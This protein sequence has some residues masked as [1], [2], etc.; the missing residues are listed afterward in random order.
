MHSGG[1]PTPC[2]SMVGGRLLCAGVFDVSCTETCG[3]TRLNVALHSLHRCTVYAC[4]DFR[5]IVTRRARLRFV[6]FGRV[7]VQWHDGCRFGHEGDLCRIC[8]VLPAGLRSCKTIV[9]WRS[10]KSAER[11]C[12][13]DTCISRRF[14]FDARHRTPRSPTTMKHAGSLSQD[15]R[16]VHETDDAARLHFTIWAEAYTGLVC[17]TAVSNTCCVNTG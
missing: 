5:R 6:I 9:A 11:S 3:P 15:S 10:R 8:L 16:A 17:P 12:L 1:L 14:L 2:A 4:F 13:V 7:Q